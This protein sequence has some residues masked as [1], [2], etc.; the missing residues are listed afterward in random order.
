MMISYIVCDILAARVGLV[1]T[2]VAPRGRRGFDRPP[3]RAG[4]RHEPPPTRRGRTHPPQ[5]HRR[6]APRCVGLPP[7]PLVGQHTI[8]LDRASATAFARSGQLR[9]GSA[10]LGPLTGHLFEGGMHHRT[11]RVLVCCLYNPFSCIPKCCW[12]PAG[13]VVA[14]LDPCRTRIQPQRR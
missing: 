7:A 9:V 11:P 8:R 6:M 3:R 4:A 1:P 14:N 10:D 2:A 12:R 13:L 5:G